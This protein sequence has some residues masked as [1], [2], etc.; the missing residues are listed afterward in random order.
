MLFSFEKNSWAKICPSFQSVHVYEVNDQ[1]VLYSF[2]LVPMM[3]TSNVRK[4]DV[5]QSGMRRSLIG[6]ALYAAE[7]TSAM[8]RTT[9]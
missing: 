2:Y 8:Q 7:A 5:L 9:F 6:L 4:R 3:F 1:F